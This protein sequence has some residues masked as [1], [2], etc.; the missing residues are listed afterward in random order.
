MSKDWKRVNI[1]LSEEEFKELRIVA[2]RRGLSM[3]TFIRGLIKAFVEQEKK[4]KVN[5]LPRK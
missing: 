4:E 2:A 3:S 5:E 1:C